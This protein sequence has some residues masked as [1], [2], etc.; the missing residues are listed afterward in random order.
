MLQKLQILGCWV[1]GFV[2]YP[3]HIT[4]TTTTH[5]HTRAHLHTRTRTYTLTCVCTPSLTLCV[6]VCVYVC[7]PPSLSP[8]LSHTNTLSLTHTLSFQCR[9]G[10]RTCGHCAKRLRLRLSVA[11]PGWDCG[12]RT[13]FCRRHRKEDR[14]GTCLRPMSTALPKTRASNDSYLLHGVVDSGV[15]FNYLPSKLSEKPYFDLGGYKIIF[16]CVF[17]AGRLCLTRAILTHFNIF[18]F[19]PYKS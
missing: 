13:V 4:T 15:F 14:Y 12:Q 5:T 11:L 19:L 18:S 17:Q 1:L 8:I 3:H 16:T 6:C 2:S 10:M 7:A 9:H